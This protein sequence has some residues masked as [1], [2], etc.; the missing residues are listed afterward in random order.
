[1]RG[2]NKKGNSRFKKVLVFVALLIVLLVLVNST[3]K[4]YQKRQSVTEALAKMNTDINE[5]KD[6]ELFLKDSE[7]RL[8]VNEGLEIEIKKKFSMARVG[9]SVAVIIEEDSEQEE[10]EDD[11]GFWNKLKKIL[12]MD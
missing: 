10:K 9:E 7:E 4:V 8:S 6:R 2:L 1:M 5:L 12:G 3:R 11:S